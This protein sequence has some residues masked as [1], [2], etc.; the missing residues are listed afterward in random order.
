LALR[1]R[2]ADRGN[3]LRR[4]HDMNRNMDLPLIRG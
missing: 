3:P 2:R 4:D 1:S